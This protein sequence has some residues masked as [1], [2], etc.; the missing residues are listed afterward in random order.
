MSTVEQNQTELLQNNIKCVFNLFNIPKPYSTNNNHNIVTDQR[1]LTPSVLSENSVEC[2]LSGHNMM[3]DAASSCSEESEELTNLTWLTELRNELLTWP[4]SV[5]PIVDDDCLDRK[6]TTNGKVA[7][8]SKITEENS[9]SPP[10]QKRPTPSERYNTFL[11]KVKKD[12]AEYD[13]AADIYQ[14]DVDEKPPFNYSHIIGMAMVENGRMTLQQICSWIESK[15]AFFRVRKRWNN[16]IRHN[17]SLH[18]CFK[19]IDRSKYEKGKGGFWELGIDPKKCDRKRIRNRKSSNKNRNTLNNDGG[20]AKNQKITSN[21][22]I[23]NTSSST[24]PPYIKNGGLEKDNVDEFVLDEL[25]VQQ[26]IIIQK[27][28]VMSSE[29]LS[30]IMSSSNHQTT[31][32]DNSRMCPY[33]INGSIKLQD[34][35]IAN[36]DSNNYNN[37]S[38]SPNLCSDAE[39]ELG[40]IIVNSTAA[41]LGV[42]SMNICDIGQHQV[43]VFAEDE[44]PEPCESV[45]ISSYLGND[46]TI[47]SNQTQPNVI[48]EQMT[49]PYCTVSTLSESNSFRPYIDGIDEAFLYLRSM[50]SRCDDL[51]DNLL[52]ISV[53]DY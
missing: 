30:S 9:T 27:E 32:D 45:V 52:D 35:F 29:F 11:D 12:I 8:N 47:G 4:D 22:D 53:S 2:S 23:I 43:N 10:Q 26:N 5:R 34:V 19:K 21:K 44:I 24:I 15:F 6:S 51:F 33:D 31:I 28:N 13:L 7:L 50:D 36:V 20:E 38:N 49:E 37:L 14:T 18:H 42:P 48:V 25:D 39:Y 40:T 1:S 41:D 17:L 16:S 3:S 46:T